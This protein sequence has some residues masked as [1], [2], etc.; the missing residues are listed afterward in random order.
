MEFSKTAVTNFRCLVGGTEASAA[1]PTRRP[2]SLEMSG[3]PTGIGLI[4]EAE[5]VLHSIQP[6]ELSLI[7]GDEKV[8]RGGGGGAGGTPR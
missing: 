6:Q 8:V 7:E 3:R 4:L 1:F 2:R 5:A